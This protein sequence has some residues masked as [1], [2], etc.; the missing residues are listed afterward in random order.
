MYLGFVYFC[1]STEL[2]AMFPSI[3]FLSHLLL[4]PNCI[5]LVAFHLDLPRDSTCPSLPQK[6]HNRI[7]IV[8][9]FPSRRVPHLSSLCL[10]VLSTPEQ[11]P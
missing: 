6:Q 7:T 4:F 8:F 1:S 11:G 10:I 2:R 3:N 9:V 5:H